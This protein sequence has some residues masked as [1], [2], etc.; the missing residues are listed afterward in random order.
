[1]NDLQDD[2]RTTTNRIG[3]VIVSRKGHVDFT[4]IIVTVPD[5][6][7]RQPPTLNYQLNRY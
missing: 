2:G 3:C 4:P 1:M 6:Q 7:K 5:I